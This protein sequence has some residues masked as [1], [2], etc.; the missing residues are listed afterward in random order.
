MRQHVDAIA[1]QQPPAAWQRLVRKVRQFLH[2]AAI[3]VMLRRMSASGSIQGVKPAE[4]DQLGSNFARQKRGCGSARGAFHRPG[5][6]GMLMVVPCPRPPVSTGR[7][8]LV[9]RSWM[10]KNIT[11]GS[12]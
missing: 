5:G 3:A 8:C 10:L 4:T 12:A 11:D 9:W 1:L 2:D 6:K 7:R